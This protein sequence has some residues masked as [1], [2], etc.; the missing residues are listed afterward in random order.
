MTTVLLVLS[1][2]GFISIVAEDF[3]KIDKAKTT[4][5]FGTLV[6]VLYFI[7]PPNGLSTLELMDSLNENLL[8]IATLW[9][10]LMAAM[11]FVA[12][13]SHKGVI[14]GIVNKVMPTHMSERR[15]M[16]ITGLFA[17][18]F[19]SMADNITATLVC[20][21]VLLSLNLSTEKLLRYIVLVV[22]AV[23]SGGAALITGDVTTLMIFLAGKV[24]IVDLVLLSLPALFAVLFLAFL[25][26]RSLKGEV[27]LVKREIEI[28]KGDQI[29]AGL[30]LATII[31][32]I[33]ANV[34]FGIPPVLSFL[35]GLAVMFM[36]VH[37]LNKDEAVLEYIRKIE[38]DTLLFFLGVLLLVGMLKE[39]HVLEHF[40]TLYEKL[41]I[42]VANYSV[43]LFSA[44]IDN[45]PLTAALL[46][47]GIDMSE[48]EWLTL[49][50]SVGVGG[51]L[52]AIGSAAGVVAM[53]KIAALSFIAYLRYFGYLLLAYTVGFL[54]VVAVSYVL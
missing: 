14:D 49:T 24:K 6:W 27:I 22:F 30:F 39:L 23:N 8:E 46:K 33:G 37:F 52:L 42:I 40:P 1:F 26:S 50:Y 45:V 7:A 11:T 28:A 47:S 21:T 5:F 4:L 15:L 20:I 48:G 41:P 31:G 53:S 19:S 43:G 25:L 51:S 29:I 32:T 17:F 35:F 12:Y 44:L 36:A 10:F 54:G 18:F 2:L 13:V 9:L 3:T 38:F 34:A 16:L